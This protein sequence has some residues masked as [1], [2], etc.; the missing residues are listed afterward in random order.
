MLENSTKDIINDVNEIINKSRQIVY[1]VI[2]IVLLQR[3]WLIGKRIYEEKIKDTRQ[4][5]YGKGFSRSNLYSFYRFYKEHQHIF[6][7]LSGQS[8][9]VLSWSHYSVLL[10]VTDLDAR[11]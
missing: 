1:Q 3:N 8:F 9:G 6:Q 5:N 2:D 4:E 7:T 10:S 11:K